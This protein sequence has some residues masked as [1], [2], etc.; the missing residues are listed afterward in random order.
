[1][2]LTFIQYVIHL[3][4]AS[5]VPTRKEDRLNRLSGHNSSHTASCTAPGIDASTRFMPGFVSIII[6]S[7]PEVNE[8]QHI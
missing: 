7:M 6:I 5:Y 2:V 4:R 1:M 8:A 3:G